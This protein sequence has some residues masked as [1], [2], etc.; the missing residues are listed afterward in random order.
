MML[1]MRV[2]FVRFSLGSYS[3]WL[4]CLFAFRLCFGNMDFLNLTFMITRSMTQQYYYSTSFYVMCV[5]VWFYL[6]KPVVNRVFVPRCPLSLS[7]LAS[8]F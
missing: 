6:C 5:C 3:R 4:C 2:V 7:H 1:A 8:K